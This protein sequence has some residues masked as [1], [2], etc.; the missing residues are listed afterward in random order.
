MTKT[1]PSYSATT[2]TGYPKET[3]VQEH[4]LIS[5][6]IKMT[7]AFDEEMNKSLK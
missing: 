5:N 4:D 7:E 3:E 1:E 6:L 2:S